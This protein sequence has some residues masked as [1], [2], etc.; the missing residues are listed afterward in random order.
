MPQ[1]IKPWPHW[2]NEKYRIATQAMLVFIA[3]VAIHILPSGHPAVTD[4]IEWD[5]EF[6]KRTGEKRVA[7][8]EF[9]A[10]HSPVQNLLL[11]PVPPLHRLGIAVVN[12]TA[13][14]LPPAQWL[15]VANQVAVGWCL[16]EEFRRVLKRC[17]LVVAVHHAGHPKDDAIALFL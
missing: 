13:A 14:S 17:I 8:V 1:G 3:G 9:P 12:E 7:A 5:G 16:L 15:S 11:Q 6:P 10:I 4:P 2:Q